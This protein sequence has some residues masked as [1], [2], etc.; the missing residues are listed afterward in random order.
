M[1]DSEEHVPP[2]GSVT[3]KPTGECTKWYLQ[4][5]AGVCELLLSQQEPQWYCDPSPYCQPPPHRLQ[6]THYRTT[7]WPRLQVIWSFNRLL[8]TTCLKYFGTLYRHKASLRVREPRI[9]LHWWDLFLQILMVCVNLG[10]WPFQQLCPPSE[11][12][13]S[14]FTL[15]PVMK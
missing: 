10:M 1:S 9:L 5:N 14:A 13:R 15:H 12:R 4:C 3:Y 7:F 2:F 6:H 8:I 11:K